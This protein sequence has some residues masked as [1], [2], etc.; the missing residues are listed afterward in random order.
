MKK[1][2]TAPKLEITYLSSCNVVSQSGVTGK[3]STG[4]VKATTLG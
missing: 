4:S 2:Y 1:T 3:R